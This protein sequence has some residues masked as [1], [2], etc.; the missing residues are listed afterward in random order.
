[1]AKWE[2]KDPKWI[3]HERQDGS[4]VNGEISQHGTSKVT[5]GGAAPDSPHVYRLAL[6]G[7]ESDGVEQAEAGGIACRHAS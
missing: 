6:G 7:K 1:M 3:V 5:C 4:N 2:D